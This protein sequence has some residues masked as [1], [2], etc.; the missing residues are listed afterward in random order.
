MNQA[1]GSRLVG[2]GAHEALQAGEREP[3]LLAKAQL[4]AAL[5]AL[6]AL[7]RHAQGLGQ[8]EVQGLTACVAVGGSRGSQGWAIGAAFSGWGDP[9]YQQAQLPG[10]VAWG[11]AQHQP[12]AHRGGTGA[13]PPACSA[14]PAQGLAQT[15]AQGVG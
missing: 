9:V 3:H 2:Q 7:G 11:P 14:P 13:P 8:N 10:S 15:P 1:L 5:A 12:S 4:L 6:A